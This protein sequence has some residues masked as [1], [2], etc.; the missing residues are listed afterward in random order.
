[1]ST[2]KTKSILVTVMLSA[3]SLAE[4]RPFRI[5]DLPSAPNGCN[6]CHTNGGGTP[7]NAFGQQAAQ[8]LVGTPVSSANVD[9]DSL[10]A[11]DADGDDASNGTELGDG[12]CAWRPGDAA[13][14]AV[15]NPADGDD[16]PPAPSNPDDPGDPV[17]P[18]VPDLEEGGCRATGSNGASP[19]LALLL[20]GLA[21]L[22]RR[23]RSVR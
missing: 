23:R 7:L 10:C 16:V 3:P 5:G 19:S 4:A 21:L 17:A 6:T 22:R 1:M 9:W 8:F 13:T 12:D 15:S 18:S 20:G 14:T 11:L 2:L